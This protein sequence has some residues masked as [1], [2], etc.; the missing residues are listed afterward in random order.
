MDAL[1]YEVLVRPSNIAYAEHWKLV[2]DFTSIE[3]AVDCGRREQQK[4]PRLEFKVCSSENETVEFVE[5]IDDGLQDEDE[6]ED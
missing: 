4:N 5:A 1:T 3:D 2:A 6:D